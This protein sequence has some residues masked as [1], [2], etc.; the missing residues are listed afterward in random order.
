MQ[1]PPRTADRHTRREHQRPV[2]RIEGVCQCLDLLDGEDPDGSAF[3]LR[4]PY[5][6]GR[7]R[8]DQAILERLPQDPASG[9]VNELDG[10]GPHAAISQICDELPKVGRPD[11]RD[12]GVYEWAQVQ[13]E[14]GLVRRPCT[15]C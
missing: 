2:T 5:P 12:R 11:G 7:V 14:L 10:P 6:G 15:R 3:S 4:R 1:V 9:L 13:P 8:R